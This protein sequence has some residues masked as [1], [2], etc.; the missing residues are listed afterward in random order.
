MVIDD[1]ER[2][3]RRRRFSQIAD[4]LRADVA[5]QAE[6]ATVFAA[7][8][9]REGEFCEILGS[10]DGPGSGEAFREALSRWARRPGYD[11]FRGF[12]QMWINQYVGYGGD[13]GVLRQAA[14]APADEAAARSQL[15][16]ILAHVE[17]IRRAGAPAPRRA[18]FV[19]SLLWCLQDRSS[20]PCMWDSA[21]RTLERSLGW[22][23]PPDDLPSLYLDYRQTVLSLGADVEEVE[24]ALR[25]LKQGHFVGLDPSLVDRCRR[26][27]EFAEHWQEG[28]GYSSAE[29]TD[30]AR[31]NATALVSELAILAG[32]LE[33][34]VASALDRQV[35]PSFP[36]I[37][38]SVGKPFRAEAWAAWRLPE[39]T[40]SGPALRAWATPNGV[41]VGLY[42]GWIRDGW[43]GEAAAEVAPLVPDGFEFFRVDWSDPSSRLVPVG[44]SPIENE[45]LLAKWYPGEAALGRADFADDI[46]AVASTLQPLVDKLAQLAVRTGPNPPS[47]PGGPRF[48]LVAMAARFRTERPY[49]TPKDEASIAERTRWAGLLAEGDVALVDPSE[50]RGI[51]STNRYGGPGP[52]SILHT[53]LRDPEQY[54]RIL[55]AI[56]FL[57]WG[58][59][60]VSERLDRVLD[61][62]DLGLRGLGESVLLKLLAI[63]HPD[64]FIPIFPLT[65]NFGKLRALRL[66][67]LSEPDAHGSRGRQQVETNDTLRARLE[68]L[69]PGDP[70]AQAQFFY[71]LREQQVVTVEAQDDVG[72]LARH[73]L[74]DRKYLDDWLA[75]LEERRQIVFYGPPGTG[76]T[77]VAQAM[78]EAI[79]VDPT[80]RMTVQFHPSTSYEDF[81]EGY[82]PEAGAD[83]RLSY[84]LTPGPL[85]QL[86]ARAEQSPGIKYVMII[87]EINRANLPRVLGELLFLLEYRDKPV[88]TLYRP[89]EPFELPANLLII[90]TMNTA[91]RSIAL[92]D[93]ALRRRF[94]FVPFFPDRPPVAGLLSR[95]LDEHDVDAQWVA[96]LVDMVNGELVADLGGPHL[97]I[98][99]SHFM[100]KGMNETD[101][102]RVWD[103]SVFPFIEDQLYGEPERIAK[104]EFSRV[105]AKYRNETGG[106]DGDAVVTPE[107]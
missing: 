27:T 96:A 42:P 34:S 78:A 16:L 6:L 35:S 89:D 8:R 70:W 73:L 55:H 83:G 98:G 72:A 30:L 85:A 60:D 106:E 41:A 44:Q 39:M 56:D 11:S 87:D 82:R 61:Q 5:Q 58:D 76:K 43:L 77:F 69:F 48:D 103:Y 10:L 71:W 33:A 53:T 79:T 22:L 24:H 9:E 15:E 74:I 7:R 92:L 91:D 50:L 4:G 107:T 105:L 31:L 2:E 104:Y 51:I 81:F 1:W 47:P 40:N 18:L 45:F 36:N 66:F 67:D 90:G 26:S 52:Q 100:R 64:R 37:V 25:W 49:P 75:L 23:I 46:L 68:P 102:R 17:P 93:A 19:L 54:D 21:A 14:T 32:R 62:D 88:H 95:W 65:G 3:A 63:A 97:Q 13:P 101:L 86:A 29:I 99:P 80:R 84:R 28:A 38:T 57:L 59:G 12:G 20:W 94:H